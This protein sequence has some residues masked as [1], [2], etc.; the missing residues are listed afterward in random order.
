MY[1]KEVKSKQT[2]AKRVKIL[3]QSWAGCIEYQFLAKGKLTHI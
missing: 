2:K 1:A 3:P